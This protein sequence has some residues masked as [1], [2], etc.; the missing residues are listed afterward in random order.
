MLNTNVQEESPAFMPHL[1]HKQTTVTLMLGCLCRTSHCLCRTS[2]CESL[3]CWFQD[4]S[5]LVTDAD[6]GIADWLQRQEL[7]QPA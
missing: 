4:L 5:C 6:W 3:Q 2:H 7:A 1:L